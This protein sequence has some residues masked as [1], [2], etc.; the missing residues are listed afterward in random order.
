MNLADGTDAWKVDVE[1]KK[2][3]DFFGSWSTPV[4]ADIKGR[5]ELVMTWPG[6]VKAYNPE[7]GSLLWSCTGLEKRTRA[8]TG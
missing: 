8:P 4:L 2:E 5:M 3:G 1:G 7:N 6:V